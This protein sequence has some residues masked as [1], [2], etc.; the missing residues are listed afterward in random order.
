MTPDRVAAYLDASALT[1]LVLDEPGS[2]ALSAHIDGRMPMS[3]DLA[4]T[5]VPRAVR[6]WSARREGDAAATVMLERVDDVFDG[7]GLVTVDTRL[8]ADAALLDPPTLR[9]LD[10]IHVAT[11]RTLGFEEFVTYDARQARAAA[12]AGL[13]PVSPGV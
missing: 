6:A 3:S 8:L 10:A 13:V 2:N 12:E 9:T 7:I 5:E 4:L 1:K 11:A